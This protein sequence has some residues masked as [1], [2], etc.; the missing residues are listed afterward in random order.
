[1]LINVRW[2]LLARS[3]SMIRHFVDVPR[4]RRVLAMAAIV[5]TLG[6][7]RLWAQQDGRAAT[8]GSRVTTELP[9]NND[10]NDGTDNTDVGL[11]QIELGMQW[12]R[13]DG[14]TRA[15]ALPV[16]ARYGA[17]E[18]LELTVGTDLVSGQVA[19]GVG[20]HGIGDLQ[21]GGRLRL[22]AARGGL[23]PL[24]VIPQVSLP[25]ADGASGLGTSHVDPLTRAPHR[26]GPAAR[27]SRG[28]RVS[29]RIG[30]RGTGARPIRATVRLH[31]GQPRRDGG[32]DTRAHG[33][34]GVAPG[35]RYRRGRAAFG[36]LGAHRIPPGGA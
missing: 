29:G 10:V 30:G 25:T 18:W 1:M 12:T 5:W 7:V 36:R 31:L 11:L 13:V 16:A 28:R 9:A 19:S 17:F 4:A 21:V 35:R 6:T 33:V 23:P 2:S 3:S 14:G 34:V 24:S 20:E 26:A 15:A 22:F 32:L 27:R 8:D